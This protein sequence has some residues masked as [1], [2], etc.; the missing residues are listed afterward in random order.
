MLYLRM[1][2]S[3]LFEKQDCLERILAISE[4]QET[5]LR[6]GLSPLAQ[7]MYAGMSDEKQ[8]LVDSA[9]TTD[10]VFGTILKE[11]ADIFEEMSPGCKEM[12]ERLQERIRNVAATDAMIR[13]QEARNEDLARPKGAP[14]PCR[15][16]FFAQY[17]PVAGMQDSM[18]RARPKGPTVP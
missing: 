11:I 8:S 1:L 18:Q 13:V 15:R 10:I 14:R 12:A 16:D 7:A 2:E 3:V 5:V 17:A 9:L 4:N 6:S